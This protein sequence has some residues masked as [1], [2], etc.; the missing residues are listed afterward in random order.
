[1]TPDPFSSFYLVSSTF[2]LLPA[3]LSLDDPSTVT[4]NETIKVLDR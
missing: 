4:E 2:L 1:M 3:K